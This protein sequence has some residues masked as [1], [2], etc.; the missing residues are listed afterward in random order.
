MNGEGGAHATYLEA[1][2]DNSIIYKPCSISSTNQF[3][4]RGGTQSVINQPIN[5]TGI[6]NRF[7]ALQT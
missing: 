6:V 3:Y 5:Q 4:L 7:T 2:S 1:M